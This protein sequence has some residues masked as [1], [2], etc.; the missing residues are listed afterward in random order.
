MNIQS[1]VKVGESTILKNALIS[2]LNGNPTLSKDRSTR[3]KAGVLY[4]KPKL[5]TT[6]NHDTMLNLDCDCGVCVFF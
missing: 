2:Q 4:M 1:N 6:K 3:I 5:L